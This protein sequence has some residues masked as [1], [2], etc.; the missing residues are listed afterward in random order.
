MIDTIDNRTSDFSCTATPYNVFLNH[1]F[2]SSNML[3]RFIFFQHMFQKYFP[4]SLIV[5]VFGKKKNL[6][7][8]STKI[9]LTFLI[10]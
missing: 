4:M 7:I 6:S 9:L 5:I 2:L 1:Q 3:K 10:Q 8:K